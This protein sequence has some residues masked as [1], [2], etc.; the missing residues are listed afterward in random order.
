MVLGLIIQARQYHYEKGT[1][2]RL[3]VGLWRE[4]I[5]PFFGDS[6]ASFLGLL[7]NI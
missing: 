6:G 7:M 3:F 5:V 2:R 1:G 4:E